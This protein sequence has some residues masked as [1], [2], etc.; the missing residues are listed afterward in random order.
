MKRCLLFTPFCICL[1]SIFA[2]LTFSQSKHEFIDHQY[3]YSV[4]HPSDWKASIYRSG[5]VV[6]NINSPDNKSGLQIRILDSN[7]PIDRF[8]NGY[9]TDFRKSMNAV[10]L[11]QGENTYGPFH[12]YW[13][14]FQSDRNGK[15][16][17]LKSYIIPAGGSR[18]FV[19]QS[20][21]PFEQRN[22]GEI[23]LDSIAS[24]FRLR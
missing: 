19:F 6:A 18:I 20:G 17:F 12:G 10:L 15:R 4:K 16:Y 2:Q 7:Q 1:L 24:S 14:T 21:T 5:I 13:A 22:S 8:V 11:D 9:V 3:R 23:I